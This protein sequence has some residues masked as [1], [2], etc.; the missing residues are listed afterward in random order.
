MLSIAWSSSLIHSPFPIS[1]TL[2]P[3]CTCAQSHPWSLTFQF[4]L[5]KIIY[6]PTTPR[7]TRKW[8]R[9]DALGP[10]PHW[11]PT[12]VIARW[13]A[14][15]E[16]EVGEIEVPKSIQTYR[17]KIKFNS[18][19]IIAKSHILLGW[20]TK[21]LEPK[22]LHQFGKILYIGRSEIWYLAGRTVPDLSVS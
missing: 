21:K 6:R 1:W 13:R 22:N 11:C 12:P 8:W 2:I 3:V 17:G 14:A 20:C 5:R 7:I 18:C 9:S 19:K 10:A 16:A 15:E 4:L